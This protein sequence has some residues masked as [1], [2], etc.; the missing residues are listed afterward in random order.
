MATFEDSSVTWALLVKSVLVATSEDTFVNL[1]FLVKFG[2]RPL[3]AHL[4]PERCWSN[5]LLVA[6]SEDIFLI[7]HTCWWPPLKLHMLQGNALGGHL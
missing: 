4:L 6:N 2:D 3:K 5:L 7:R 1:A